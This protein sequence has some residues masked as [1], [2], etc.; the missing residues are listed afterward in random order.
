[1][2]TRAT[3]EFSFRTALSQAD[4]IDEIA[5]NLSGLSRTDFEN[6]MQNLSAGWKGENASLYL[7]KGSI[8][9]GKMDGTSNSLHAVASDI[10]AVAKRIYD[11]EMA[12][13]EIAQNRTY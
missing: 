11:A 13:L 9:Q 3:I 12:A 8:L 2:A 4:T 10:R 7:S 6:A 5:D 1:M